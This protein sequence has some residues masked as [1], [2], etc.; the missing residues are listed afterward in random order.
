MFN[1]SYIDINILIINLLKID[2]KIINQIKTI[3]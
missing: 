1:F 3:L 2:N